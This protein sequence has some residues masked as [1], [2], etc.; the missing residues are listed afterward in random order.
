MDSQPRH[1][2]KQ[3]PAVSR[4]VGGRTALLPTVM[5]FWLAAQ[6]PAAVCADPYYDQGVRLY[7]Q[8]NFRSAI[9]YFE[10][11]V[12]DNPQNSAAQYYQGL[13]YQQLHDF[14]RAKSFYRQVYQHFPGSQEARMSALVLQRIDPEFLKAAPQTPSERQAL[15]TS[16]IGAGALSPYETPKLTDAEWK[17]LPEEAKVPFTRGAGGHIYVDAFLNNRPLKMMFDTGASGCVVSRD[18]LA[19]VQINV[20]SGG[21][22]VPFGGVGGV[23]SGTAMSAQLQVGPISRK[24]VIGVT[25]KTNCQPL[26]GETFFKPF[27]YEIDNQGGFIRF[28]KKRRDGSRAAAEPLDTINVPFVS[29][30]NNFLVQAKVNGRSCPMFFDTGAY[31]IAFSLAQLPALGIAIPADAQPITSS[32]VSGVTPGYKFYVDSIELG[33]V[34]QTHVPITVL[35]SGP[36]F[37]LLGQSF[38]G[39]R[40]FT[41]DQ[42][43][44]L[45]KFW[46]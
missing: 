18:Q 19:S 30:G 7:Q 13:A 36:P 14:E 32:G 33:P 24:L 27:D 44:H 2:V 20:P 11:V 28:I 26:L 38:I 45:I 39:G 42:Q 31:G 46:R 10:Q 17:T 35:A 23:T 16:S 43:N 41:I 22:Q 34:I 8:G 9:Q 21:P 5:A 25:D 37:P 6:M 4:Q 1:W 15:P 3:L 12:K 40:R 29:M